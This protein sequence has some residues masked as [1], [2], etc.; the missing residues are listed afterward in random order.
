MSD[1]IRAVVQR[2]VRGKHGD[3]AVATS[4][5]IRDGSVTFSLQRSVWGERRGSE[6]GVI[7]VLSDLEKKRG[8]WRAHKARFLK[9]A[10]E[11]GERG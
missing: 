4:E 7:V 9:P 1:Q 2:I 5:A 3:Y 6:R 8:G 10:D 11:R